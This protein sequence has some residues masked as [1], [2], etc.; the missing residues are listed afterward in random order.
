M[1]K[2][3]PFLSFLRQFGE[4]PDDLSLAVQEKALYFE[5]PKKHIL[6]KKDKVCGHLYYI[7]SGLARNFYEVDGKELTTD[8]SIDNQLLVSFSSFISQ[9]P[10]IESIELLEDCKLYAL[11]Y[12]DLQDLYRNFKQMERL[13]RL[14]AEHHYNSLYK[15]NYN[16]KFRSTTERYE[17]LF[18][19]KIE[20]I[21][22]VPIG[23]IASYLGMT[24]ETLSRIRSKQD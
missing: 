16:F 22:R 11:R 1:I 17:A 10:S 20:I 24:I 23:I 14:M 9:T 5:L 15:K 18:N 19:S 8:I 13:G 4:L 3:A 21:K 12:E 2:A 6:L 7:E